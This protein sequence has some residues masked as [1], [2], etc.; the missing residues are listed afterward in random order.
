MTIF[1]R[2]A[3]VGTYW[4]G[5][6]AC[7]TGGFRPKN[8]SIPNTPDRVIQ[9]VY[10]GLT[11]S[12]Y[13]SLTLSYGVALNYALDMGVKQPTARDPAYV[14][15]IEINAAHGVMLIDPVKEVANGAPNPLDPNPYQHNGHPN[16]MLGVTWPLMASLLRLPVPVPPGAA[17]SAAPTARIGPHLWAMIAALRDAEILAIGDIPSGCVLRRYSV[18]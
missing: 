7:V 1:Y 9:H 16:V 11:D 8:R 10:N 12:P 17:T 15:E 5:N 2:G 4:H 3:G 6:N 14:Y 13:V 18:C